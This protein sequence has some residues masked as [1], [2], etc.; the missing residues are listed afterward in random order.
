[1]LEACKK[2][3]KIREERKQNYLFKSSFRAVF[4]SLQFSIF[5]E[6]NK[7]YKILIVISEYCS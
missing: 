7:I 1:M 3:K 2:K 6:K 5:Y 4:I